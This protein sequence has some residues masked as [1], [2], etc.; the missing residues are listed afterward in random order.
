MPIEEVEKFILY[1]KH[2]PNIPSAE[3]IQKEGLKVAEVTTLMMEKIE[4]MMLYIIEQNTQ[5][6]NLKNELDIL[7]NQK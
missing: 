2:L 1:N 6:K 5:I 4:E 3:Y 7:K